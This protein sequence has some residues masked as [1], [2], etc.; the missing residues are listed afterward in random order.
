MLPAT[1]LNWACYRSHCA[2]CCLAFLH[3]PGSA[4]PPEDPTPALQEQAGAIDKEVRALKA[5]DDYDDDDASIQRV[6]ALKK[7]KERVRRK[8][9]DA[10]SAR[11]QAE[12]QTSTAAALVEI[13]SQVEQEYRRVW[14]EVRRGEFDCVNSAALDGIGATGAGLLLSALAC[15]ASVALLQDLGDPQDSEEFLER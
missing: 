2:C 12:Q 8:I 13:S 4:I 7:Q 11:Q 10:E 9:R 1:D 14:H 15:S 5:R 6:R 3:A